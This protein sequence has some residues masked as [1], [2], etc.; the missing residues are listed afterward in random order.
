[1]WL[2]THQPLLVISD[3]NM[4]RMSGYDLC[5]A[6]KNE[7]QLAGVPVILLT[8]LSDP[9]DVVRGLECGAENFITKPYDETP[10]VSCIAAVLARHDRPAPPAAGA[11]ATVVY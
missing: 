7:P 8:S 6:I 3:I 9:A 10:L 4:P 2:A 5:R 11:G 1:Q